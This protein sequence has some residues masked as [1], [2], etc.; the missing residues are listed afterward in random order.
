M[1]KIVNDFQLEA[2]LW[3]LHCFSSHEVL[4]NV[5]FLL[6]AEQ[7][8]QVK[9][10]FLCKE[11]HQ[12]HSEMQIFRILIQKK[13]GHFKLYSQAFSMFNKDTQGLNLKYSF[14]CFAVEEALRP[15]WQ[16]ALLWWFQSSRQEE[17]CICG[18]LLRAE[19]NTVFFW[20]Y[21]SGL[22]LGF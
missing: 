1:K 5:K 15:W 9:S 7:P 13:S 14:K 16:K 8:F 20:K 10:N 21:K 12:F 4:N 22:S 2:W 19:N 18:I 3:G 11:C 6:S 17:N